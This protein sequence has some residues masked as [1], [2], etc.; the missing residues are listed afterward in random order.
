MGDRQ[1]PVLQLQRGMQTASLQQGH[2][3]NQFDWR[4]PHLWRGL[5]PAVDR[6]IQIPKPRIRV[7]A[8]RKSSFRS[9][10]PV[11]GRLRSELRHLR[12]ETVLGRLRRRRRMVRASSLRLLFW[13]QRRLIQLK[14]PLYRKKERTLPHRRLSQLATPTPV[15]DIKF[16]T[17]TSTITILIEQARTLMDKPTAW[18]S[19][20][21]TGGSPT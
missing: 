2:H 18:R 14:L 19:W 17:Y 21:R 9:L 8:R 12:Q 15:Q 7:L 13:F 20:K 5:R 6:L 16:N 11:R 3:L 10:S 1:D 4:H